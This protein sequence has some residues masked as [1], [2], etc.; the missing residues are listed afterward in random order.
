MVIPGIFYLILSL[1]MGIFFIIVGCL[2]VKDYIRNSGKNV[3]L[4]SLVFSFILGIVGIMGAIYGFF[5]FLVLFGFI[6]YIIFLCSS[7]YIS[8]KYPRKQEEYQE[9]W[10][11]RREMYKN[12]PQY[13]YIK[14]ARYI[15]LA[16]AI[17]L[18][19]FIIIVVLFNITF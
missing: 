17:F 3:S 8:I 12:S 11:I 13:K 16:C 9:Q 2:A 10:E 1:I 19:A 14:I 18:T 15:M 4:I 7:R 5:S 6:S